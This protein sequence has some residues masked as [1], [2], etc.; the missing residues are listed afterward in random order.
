[1]KRCFFQL[2]RLYA[3]PQAR[4]FIHATENPRESQARVLE[5]IVRDLKLTEYGKH[6]DIL[7]T[8]DFRRKLPIVSYDDLTEW[9]ERQK[10]CE[11]GVLVHGAVQFYEKTSGS[12]GPSKYIPYT[13]ALRKSFS[14]MFLIWAH[15]VISGI[16]EM[17]QG[18]LYFS[19]SPSFDVET[20]TE[21]GVPIGLEDDADY[22]GEGLKHLLAPFLLMPEGISSIEDPE[23]FKQ[24]VCLALLRESSL[25]SISIW[26]PSFLRVLLDWIR[27]HRD[28]LIEEL[29]EELNSERLAA[30]QL[31]D[32]DWPGV[33][34]DLK[35][36]SCWADANAKPLAKDLARLFPEV[37]VQGKGLLA[38]EAPMTIPM[39]GVEGGVPLVDEVYFEFETASGKLLELHE[40]EAGETYGMIISQKGGLVRY[41]MGD[42]VRVVSLFH[43]TPTLEFV[44]RGNTVS[45]LVGEKLSESFVRKALE[46]LGLKETGFRCLMPLREPTEGYVL[47]LDKVAGETK[48]L[49][50]RL[51]ASLNEAFHYR[52]AR[53]LGQLSP[54]KVVCEPAIESLMGDYY[55]RAGKR[56]GDM[57]S[58]CLLTTPLDAPLLRALG[59]LP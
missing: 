4:Q 22:L 24:A 42:Y 38:T 54:L 33:W 46:E 19:I 13:R 36:I 2:A 32:I 53:Q 47:V 15:D 18:K 31:E 6:W 26:N 25:E 7:S 35:F 11:S 41:R 9:I 21:S 16:P 29:G 45:D 12:T 50:L 44:G 1:M 39:L 40:L 20:S 57:K 51:E 3:W 27:A 14:R 28:E 37:M 17:G 59:L 56:W 5:R 48:E 10:R 58:T 55:M 34:P 23:R 43:Q 52:H 8:M 49:E 30:L